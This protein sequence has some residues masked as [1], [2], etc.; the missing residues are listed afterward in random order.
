MF[1]VSFRV[2]S[3]GGTARGEEAADAKAG[4]SRRKSDGARKGGQGKGRGQSRAGRES[5]VG[6]GGCARAELERAWGW[7]EHGLTFP[8]PAESAGIG[9]E[10]EALAGRGAEVEADAEADRAA[11]ARECS[12]SFSC[13]EGIVCPE[14]LR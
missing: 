2:G 7:A 11:R 6:G 3:Q 10:L 4:W 5:E 8:N 13:S 12:G 14:A 9:K 1:G